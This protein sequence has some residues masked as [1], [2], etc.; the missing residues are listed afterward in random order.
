MLSLP[1]CI[2]ILLS[3]PSG[4]SLQGVRDTP[5]LWGSQPWV[6]F[7]LGSLVPSSTPA[8]DVPLSCGPPGYSFKVLSIVLTVCRGAVTHAAL[9]PT[10]NLQVSGAGSQPYPRES[11][12]EAI[13][14]LII[15]ASHIFM[16]VSLSIFSLCFHVL[17]FFF[18]VWLSGHTW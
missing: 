3:S 2:R 8:P 14:M 15:Q 16:P 7:L 4:K 9:C 12:A 6:N 10:S 1:I 5:V 18:L 13:P 17:I 11:Q